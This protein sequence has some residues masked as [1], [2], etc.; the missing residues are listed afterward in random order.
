M[1]RSLAILIL[2]ISVVRVVPAQ[3]NPSKDRIKTFQN[4]VIESGDTVNGVQCFVCSVHVR[5]H[6][7]GDI[8]TVGGAIFVEGTGAVDGDAVA[9]GGRIEAYS[10]SKI[11]GDAVAVGGYV[12]RSDGSAIEGD[13]VSVPYVV[14]PGQYRP[15]LLGGLALAVLNVFFVSL[16]YLAL[17]A[18]RAENTSRAIERR[19]GSVLFSGIVL[20]GLLY[21]LDS[22][23]R[24]LGRAEDWADIA[25]FTFVLV[26]AAAGAAGLGYWVARIA[27]PET[28]GFWAATGGILALTLLELVPLLG[29]LV[30]AVG[31]LLSLGAVMVSR[32]GSREVAASASAS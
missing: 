27:F 4:I 19:V 1:T 29:F 30:F 23:T 32:F 31:L 14:I 24:Y 12:E 21:G 10:N 2:L 3:T 16:A 11:S 13:T 22:L 7:T 6:V 20:L 9:A 26:I 28:S 15:T 25:L 18:K 5:G 8:V 17:Q